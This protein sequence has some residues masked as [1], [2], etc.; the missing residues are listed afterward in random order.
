MKK[1]YIILSL[2]LTALAPLAQE[3]NNE[4]TVEREI[5]LSPGE[6]RPLELRPEIT[7]PPLT[8]VNLPFSHDA[9]TTRV[10]DA[11]TTLE[12]VT[13]T[14]PMLLTNARGY[15]QLGL[16]PLWNA[17]LSAGYR[18]IDNKKTR[19]NAWLQ[20]DGSVYR[21]AWSGFNKDVNP[22]WREHS[23]TADLALSHRFNDVSTLEA[24]IDYTF[25]RFNYNLP[26]SAQIPREWQSSNNVGLRALWRSQ[27]SIFAYQVYAGYRRFAY[28]NEVPTL[29]G[30]ALAARENRF[31]VGGRAGFNFRNNIDLGLK[32]DLDVL[33]SRLRKGATGV[34]NLTPYIR[35]SGSTWRFEAGPRIEMTFNG[36]KFFHIAPEVVGGWTPSPF[37]G[38]EVRTGGGEH[39]NSLAS[40]SYAA[41]RTNPAFCYE[42]SHIPLTVDLGITVGPYKGLSLRLFGG[43]ASANDWLMPILDSQAIGYLPSYFDKFNLRAFHGGAELRARWNGLIDFTARF[44]AFEGGVDRAYYL[45]RDRACQVLDLK[46]RVTPLRKLDIE[47]SWQLRAN[48]SAYSYTGVLNPATGEIETKLNRIGLHNVSNLCVGAYYA[49]N[50]HFG[51]FLQ[52][53]NLLNH[54]HTEIDGSPSQ[55]I[56]GLVGATY[57]F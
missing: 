51:V 17:S 40:L 31:N 33:D 7:L 41:L 29:N 52:G 13:W 47:A 19:L 12:P 57:K 44:E 6:V 54:N 39:F 2:M 9:V 36:G 49:I 25:G 45:N 18:I 30:N 11:L 34:L 23:V 56:S 20:Y 10:P 21:R 35:M 16:F 43:W 27:V 28:A 8:A 48:R 32:V 15:V 46:L 24:N 42:L 5:A 50:K 55:G 37:F 4:I 22:Y 38:I 26:V 3:L 14:D 53:V 1:L